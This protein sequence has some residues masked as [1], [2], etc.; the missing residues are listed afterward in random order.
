MTDKVALWQGCVMACAGAVQTLSLLPLADL[1][2]AG[3]R[4][5][6]MGPLI[7]PTVWRDKNVALAQDLELLKAAQAFVATVQA[8]VDKAERR[9][10]LKVARS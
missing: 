1:I 5:Q 10:E 2:A 4:S 3:E 6:S 8:A 7:N 9:G